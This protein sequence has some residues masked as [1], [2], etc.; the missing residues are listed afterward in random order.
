MMTQQMFA[1]QRA[2]QLAGNPN[3]AAILTTVPQAVTLPMSYLNY[4]LRPFD[5]PVATCVAS[6]P[7]NH[8]SWS[9][10]AA[11][12]VGLIVRPCSLTRA[13][14]LTRC[15]VCL[16]F[17][18]RPRLAVVHSSTTTHTLPQPALSSLPPR[19]HS[20]LRLS[21][22]VYCLRS[23]LVRLPGAFLPKVRHY[24]SSVGCRRIEQRADSARAASSSTGCCAITRCWRWA[25]LSRA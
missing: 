20:S 1:S 18:L 8:S 19:H 2:S 13:P 6:C 15:Q 10:R 21:L 12:Y 7:Q 14:P 4:D 11:T 9:S 22:V 17:C 5:V 16:H 25:T 24:P 23:S 3:L